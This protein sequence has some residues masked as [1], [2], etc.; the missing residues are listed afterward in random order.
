MV[1]KKVII[2]IFLLLFSLSLAS[3]QGREP[4]VYLE[5]SDLSAFLSDMQKDKSYRKFMGSSVLEW[6]KNSRLGLKFPKRIKEF[7]DVLGFALSV[8]NINTLAGKETGIWLFDIGELEMLMITRIPESD[9]L[10]SRIAQSKDRFGEGKI[11]TITFYFKKDESGN[12]EVDFAFLNDHLII[13]NEP[14]AFEHYV[15]RLAAADNYL[16]WKTDDF[17]GWMEEPIKEEYDMLLYLS[18]ESVRNTYFTSYWFHGNQEEIRAWFDQGII[19]LTK[20]KKEITEKRIYR[21]VEGFA[22]DSLALKQVSRLFGVVPEHADMVKIRP[23][24][25]EELTTGLRKL[26]GGG[27][28][29]DS[30]IQSV[31]D[32]HPLA[33][34]H[35]AV[36]REGEIL[37][38]IAEGFAVVVQNPDKAIIKQFNDIYPVNLRT[39]KLFSKNMADLVMEHNMLF[40]ATESEFF[41]KRKSINGTD[42]VSYSFLDFGKFATA[43]SSEIDLLAKSERWRSY[44]NRDFFEKNIGDLVRIGSAYLLKIE[45]SGKISSNLIEDKILYKLR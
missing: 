24:Y 7:E 35:F 15:R 45:R 9:Y 42:L 18:S 8:Q 14:T 19:L 16:E 29:M 12:R 2:P 43:F 23:V 31:E 44:E 41:K 13:S 25:G 39:H 17:L 40:F 28:S 30:L 32:M 20:D 11:G 22:F 3:G 4:I 10:R 21:L 1:Y 34:G 6:Y 38:E 26:I 36:V 27:K 5:F 37:P 33:Y